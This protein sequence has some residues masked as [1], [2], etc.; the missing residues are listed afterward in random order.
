MPII[1]DELDNMSN[2]S[3]SVKSNKARDEKDFMYLVGFN[4][5][6]VVL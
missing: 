1:I 5:E 4:K 3:S 6:S 2:S